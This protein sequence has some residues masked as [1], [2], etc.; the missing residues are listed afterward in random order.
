MG[1]QER[2]KRRREREK[3]TLEAPGGEN[4]PAALPLQRNRYVRS[5]KIYIPTVAPQRD[6]FVFKISKI[7]KTTRED[8][9]RSRRKLAETGE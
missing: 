1:N 7:G 4:R 6:C 9:L 3:V 5:K 2:G 8:V